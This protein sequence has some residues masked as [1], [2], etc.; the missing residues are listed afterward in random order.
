MNLTWNNLMSK[1][2]SSFFSNFLSM[3][4]TTCYMSRNLIVIAVRPCKAYQRDYH[5]YFSPHFAGSILWSLTW[6]L[7]Q[8]SQLLHAQGT[9]RYWGYQG[10]LVTINA[11]QVYCTVPQYRLSALLS[12]LSLPASQPCQ[13]RDLSGHSHSVVSDLA[14]LFIH[15]TT[16]IVE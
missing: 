15:F 14:P 8:P 1:L 9:L 6:N 11:V 10:W 5:W 4:F 13:D 3:F 7:G 2:T 16:G 12:H